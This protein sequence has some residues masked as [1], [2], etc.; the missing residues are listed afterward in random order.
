MYHAVFS[1]V[2]RV[3]LFADLSRPGDLDLNHTVNLYLSPEEGIS[4]GIWHTVPDS[5]WQKAQG[6]DLEWYQQTL[7]NG[8]PVIIYL[9]GNG[10]TR[11]AGHRVGLVNVLSAAGFHV[12]A[13]DY[14]GFGDSSGEPTEA[15]LTTDALYLYQWVKAHSG[16]S[17]VILWGHSLGTGVA[18]NTALELQEQGVTVDGVI[19]EGAFS[20]IRQAGASHPFTMFY[21]KFPYF[22]YFFLDTISENKVVFPN[23]E[24]MRKLRSPLL[25]LHAEDDHI[26]PFHMGQELFEIAQ[27]SR[28][29]EKSVRMVP[30]EGSH[31]YRHNGLYQEPRLPAIIKQFVQSLNM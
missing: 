14:R 25:I 15:G 21:R 8:A 1:H 23:D 12:L 11:G 17:L 30:F 6:K 20:N 2:A 22:E 3:P 5:L 31:G 18:T 4:L 28:N 9:H 19:L 24:N 27:Q 26:I 29:S 13:L 7:Q 10:G 16:S